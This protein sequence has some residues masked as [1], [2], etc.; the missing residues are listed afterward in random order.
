MS[1]GR[2]LLAG[3]AMGMVGGTAP[4]T[5]LTARPAE[6]APENEQLN[7]LIE[8]NVAMLE[9]LERIAVATERIAQPV[10]VLPP[11]IV[12]SQQQAIVS[13]PPDPEMLANAGMLKAELG[14]VFIPTW[15]TALACPLGVTTTLPFNIPPGWVTYRRRPVEISSDFYDPN[16]GV[17]VYSDD[18]LIN[19]AAPMPLTGPFIVDMGEYV[20]QWTALRFD[21]ING[22]LV[23][24][25]VS[26]Q[27]NTYLIDQSF[28]DSFISPMIEA[29]REKV[30][31]LIK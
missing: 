18:V 4:A 24:A 12:I 20:T 16:I 19:P 2:E 5:L 21:V 10:L 27:I 8:L 15:R 7:Y 6:A 3:G 14:R 1:N 9:R 30:E 28:W 23:N 17:N 29:V 25:V 22:T 31:A 13:V 11:E 26:F